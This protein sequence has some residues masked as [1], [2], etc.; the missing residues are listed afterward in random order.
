MNATVTDRASYVRRCKECECAYIL[1]APLVGK[2]FAYQIFWL[3]KWT[4]TILD[5]R[6]DLA[7]YEALID[8]QEQNVARY[9]QKVFTA[10]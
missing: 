5:T 10:S 4:N 6:C 7:E 3:R 2:D 1:L 8:A 9:I